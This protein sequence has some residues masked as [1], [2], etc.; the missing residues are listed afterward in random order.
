MPVELIEAF[1]NVFALPFV[2]IVEGDLLGVSQQVA[3]QRPVLTLKSL[4]L[5]RET[6][7]SR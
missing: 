5:S 7:E 1:V 2:P 6:A 3:V 4:L